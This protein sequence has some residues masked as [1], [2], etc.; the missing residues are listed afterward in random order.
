MLETV[1]GIYSV[2]SL[3]LLFY[4]IIGKLVYALES[5]ELK[6]AIEPKCTQQNSVVKNP[7]ANAGDTGLIPGSGRSGGGNGNPLHSQVFLPGN[8][9]GQRSLVGYSPWGHKSQT[10]LSD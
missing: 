8:S 10:E 6:K 4:N 5:R 9:H 7:P 3:L 2:Y 1:L